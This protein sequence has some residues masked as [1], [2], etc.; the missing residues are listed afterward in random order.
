MLY[1]IELQKDTN[2]LY[3]LNRRYETFYLFLRTAVSVGDGTHQESTKE[4]I[5]ENIRLHKEVLQSVKLQPWSM[6]RKL[7][8][9]RQVCGLVD[10][11]FY[12]R[13]YGHD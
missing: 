9:V 6:R 8:L 4:Q 1:F 3:G 7:R 2:P 5:F 11:V 10:F 12:H 13:R